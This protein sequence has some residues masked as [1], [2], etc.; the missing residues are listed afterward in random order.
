MNI[1]IIL[2]KCVN[3]SET[4]AAQFSSSSAAAAKTLRLKF[5]CFIRS[6]MALFGSNS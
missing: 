6:C 5:S 4:L 1:K 2:L 3:S